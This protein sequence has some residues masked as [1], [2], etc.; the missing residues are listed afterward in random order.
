MAGYTDSVFR[1]IAQSLGAAY[2][3]SEMIS[4]LALVHGDTKTAALAGIGENES[5]TVLQ[6]FG[7]DPSAMAEAA[8]MLLSRDFPGCSYKN[9]PAGIDIN[10]GCPVKKITSSGD[11][12]ALMK[13]PD[14]A[15]KITEACAAVCRRYSVP[16]S[17][18]LRLGWDENSI[19][20]PEFAA[21][22][23]GSGADKLTLHTRTRE[24]LYS[25]SARPEFCLR[26]REAVPD[27]IVL[28]G[29]G[30]ISS[31]ADA[32]KYLSY[33]CGEVAVGRAAL[34][35]PWLFTE[36]STGEKHTPDTDE[37]IN[38]AV[39]FTRRVVQLKGEYTGVREARGRAAHFIK[40]MRGSAGVRD[41]LNRA[42]TEA[43][44]EEILDSLR[45]QRDE[46]RGT[47]RSSAAPH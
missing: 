40:G 9:P 33:G 31:L 24:Q 41:R 12:S 28:V 26:V 19:N 11:G 36:L 6:I 47:L 27:N 42:E 34:G 32:E 2:A 21:L 10:M 5:G 45:G 44:F 35:N 7:H 20:A 29:N 17:V 3:V 14:T 15:A 30:D 37:I 16:L 38:L 22:L 13:S 1:Q 23:A 46:S 39:E 8:E 4:S 18:K 25:P 43:E